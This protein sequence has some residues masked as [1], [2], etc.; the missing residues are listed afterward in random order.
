MADFKI[1]VIIDSFRLGVDAGIRKA[2]EVGADGIQIYAT[3]GEMAPESLNPARRRELLDKVDSQGLVISALVGDLGGHGFMDAGDNTWRIEKSKRIMELA[4]ELGTRVV[5]THIG[6]VPSDPAHPRYR[7]LQDACGELARFGD[8]LGAYFA[9]ETGPEPADVLRS[10]L[11]SLGA[12][13]VRV[14]LDPANFVMVTGDDPVRAVKLLEPYIVHTHAKDGI[15]LLVKNPEIIYGM[16]EDAIQEGEAFRE[17][18]LGQGQ[19]NFP[20]YLKALDEINF[21]GF[22]TIEREV[23]ENPEQDIRMAVTFLKENIRLL[24][25]A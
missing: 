15:R 4:C 19:V 12:T 16:I 14:N 10:F 7:V 23:G 25:Q 17:V 24:N 18:P 8:H 1:G 22:L 21:H 11:D 5:T 13:G 3:S 9:I 20:A 6:V 2:R